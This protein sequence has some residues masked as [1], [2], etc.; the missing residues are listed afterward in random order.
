MVKTTHILVSICQ[1][2]QGKR[3]LWY[4]TGALASEETKRKLR[5]SHRGEKNGHYGKQ[6]TDGVKHRISKKEQ[7]EECRLEEEKKKEC[8]R[9]ERVSIVSAETRRKMSE[10]KA[11]CYGR[12]IV[13]TK[14][15]G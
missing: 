1:K 2:K 8:R 13:I 15:T 3:Y 11:N 10:K 6:H 7:G 12:N 9:V 4:K 5:E 14:R